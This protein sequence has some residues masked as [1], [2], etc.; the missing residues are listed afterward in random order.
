MTATP[1]PSPSPRLSGDDH[2]VLRGTVQLQITGISW[3]REKN[4]AQKPPIRT[5]ITSRQNGKACRRPNH[6]LC[7][8]VFVDL[9]V[10]GKRCQD[11]LVSEDRVI[12]L[13]FPCAP[14]MQRAHFAHNLSTQTLLFCLC[15]LS[16]KMTTFTRIGEEETPSINVDVTRRLSKIDPNIY[17]GFVE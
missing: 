8:A 13:E 7:L 15:K 6:R 5:R 2:K 16:F 1:S 12:G 3:G 4:E 14:I 10:W 11:K 9:G 17:G